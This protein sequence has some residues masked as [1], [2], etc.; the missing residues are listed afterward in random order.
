MLAK[1]KQDWATA[2]VII[3]SWQT[4]PWFLQFV[5]LVKPGTT[6]L[7]IPAHQHLLQLPGANLQHPIWDRLSLIAAIFSGTSQQRDCH[8]KLPRSSEHDGGSAQSAYNT[9]V[10]RWLYFYNRRQLNPHQP[11]VSQ[12]LDFLHTLYELR[13]SYS[14]TGTHQSVISALI[15]ILGVP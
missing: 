1:L 12:V 2:W 8:L 13:L 11:T 5:R 7:L 6:T 9:S 15:E 3:P 4:Q 10:Q 14:A